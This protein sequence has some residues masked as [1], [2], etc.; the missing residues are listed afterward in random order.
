MRSQIRKSSVWPIVAVV[1]LVAALAGTAVAGSGPTADSAG[2]A[3][4]ALKLAKKNKRKIKKLSKQEGPAGPSGPAG[5]PGTARAYG[6]VSAAG[7]L[8][9]SKNVASVKHDVT[10]RYCITLTEAAAV[11]DATK[12]PIV[13]L[14]DFATNGTSTGSDNKAHVEANS[15][16][17]ICDSPTEEFGVQTFNADVNGDLTND[18]QSFNF[19]VP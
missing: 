1:A 7:V 12:H 18:D 14:T 9:N 5:A 19:V 10:G 11:P 6:H 17:D 8:S 13:A 15:K 3:G 2:K 4:K 16:N